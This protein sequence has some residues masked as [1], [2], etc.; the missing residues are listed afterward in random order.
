MSPSSGVFV[1]LLP[2]RLPAH[3]GP[4][5]TAVVIDILRATSVITQALASGCEAAVPCLEIEEARRVSAGLGAGVGLLG[6]ERKGL[7]IEGFELGNSPGDYTPERCAGR[8]LVITTTNGTRAVRACLG[9]ERILTGSFLNLGATERFLRSIRG[10]RERG[11]VHLVCAGTDGEVSWEDTIFA[12]VLARR[13]ASG[14]PGDFVVAN[15]AARIAVAAAP[16]EM[17]EL[18]ALLRQGQGGRNVRT[19]GLEGDIDFVAGVDTLKFAVV[20]ERGGDRLAAFRR[21]DGSL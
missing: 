21:A 20:L 10:S 18:P 6:G 7:P 3:P 4:G 2:E 14:R 5:E 1:H 9:F 19:I 13:L 17:S 16:R 12:G 11:A 8:S 15:D